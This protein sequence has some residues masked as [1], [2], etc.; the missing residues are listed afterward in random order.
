[1]RFRSQFFGPLS[2]VGL[3]IIAAFILGPNYSSWDRPFCT[4]TD[5]DSCWPSEL[6]W[7]DLNAS[8]GGRLIAP[9]PPASVCHDPNYDEAECAA[10]RE[11]WVWP[12]IHESWPGGIQSPYWQNSSCDPFSPVDIPC[13][14]GHSVSYAIN[15][16]NAE[17]VVQG[18]SFVRRHSLR[19]AIKNTGHD[20]MGKSTA[21]GGLALWTSSLRSIE[22]LDFASETY[23]GPAIRMGAGVR[24]LEAYT[25][26][27]NK[28]LRVVGGFCPT[29]GVAGGYTQGGG[30]GP[31]SSQYGLGADQVL[32]W[33]VITPSGEHVV[34][35]PLQHSDLYWALSGGGPGTYAVVISL[36]VRAYPDAYIGGATLAFSTAGVAKDD[37]WNFFKSWQDLLPSLTTAGGTA[38]YAVT[39]DA[40]FIAP[41]TLP[42]WTKQQVSGLISPLVDRLDE[43][44]VQYMLEVTSEPTFLKHYS[45][46]GGPLP[47]GPYT[48]HHLFGGRMI[49]RSIVE[50]NSTALVGAFRSILEDTDAFLGFVAL[51]VKQAPGREPVADNAVLPAWRDTLITVLAQSTWNFSALRADGQRHADEITDVVVPR[52]RELTLGSGTYMNEGDF[53]LKTWKED[54][55]G[56]NYPRLQAIKS[57]YDPEGLLFGPTGVSSDAWSVDEQGRLCKGWADGLRSTGLVRVAMLRAWA[58]L[59]ARARQAQQLAR[60]YF[61]ISTMTVTPGSSARASGS[62]PFSTSEPRVPL[63]PAETQPQRNAKLAGRPGLLSQPNNKIKTVYDI[64][65][66]AAETYGDKPALGSG[67]RAVGLQRTDK[68]LVYAATRQVF[69][70]DSSENPEID[71]HHKARNAYEALGL[72]GLEHSLESTGAKAIFVD[73]HLCQKV[74]SAMTNRALP[75]VEAIVYND[76]PSGTCDSG[77]AWIRGLFELKKTRPGLQILSFSQLCQ[78]GR[79]KM[80]EPVQPDREDLCAIYYTSGSTGIPKGVPVKHKAAVAAV[81]GLDSVIGDYLSPSDSFLAYL[82]LAHVLEFAFENSCLFWGVKMGYGGARTLFD[83]VT[84]SGTLGAGDLHAFQ[85][86][87]MI[88]VPAIWERI[89][90]AIFSSVENSSF[91]DRL[92]FWSWLKAKQIWAAAGFAGTGG[93]NGILSSAASEVVG[94]RLRFAMSGGGPVAESTQNFLTMVMAPLVNGYGLTETMAMGGLMDPGQWQPGSMS[95]PASIEMKLVDYPDAGYL[96]SNTPSQGEIWIRG[97]SVMEGYYDNDDES[98]SAV[99]PDGWLRTG[100]IGQ[101]EP[102]CSGDDFHFRIIDRKKNLVKTL[103]GEYIALEKLESIYRSANLVAN[104]CIHAS[105]YRAKPTAIVIPSPPALKELVKRHGLDTHCKVSALTR[106]PLVVHDALMQLQRIAQEAGL[107]SIEVVEAI[108]L[109]DDAEWTPQNVSA[110]IQN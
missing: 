19:L 104:I 14:L 43:L 105:P 108:V 63:V 24:G 81:T 51:D 78:V 9:V 59:T 5:G 98:K 12:E 10:I 42:G 61:E 23:T 106:H 70:L 65:N 8:V 86:T 102:T 82:P 50:E 48:I 60:G 79:S 38:G 95:I 11:D 92:A 97:D 67:L 17:D 88:G 13:T 34:A 26:A 72:A 18:L 71:A 110:I 84:P 47:R 29:V 22:V 57:K 74:T 3:A 25:A 80:S 101:W 64:V 37:F 1:M 7:Q 44:G 35:T 49:P 6:Q 69:P 87:F 30:H 15:V 83:H 52:L 68:I 16:T 93:F 77:A 27:A 31:L 45:K 55:Y 73:H 39:K 32:E 41:I 109:V 90:K 54:F 33:E 4:C 2:I 46:H 40:F 76:Q 99:A 20:Y 96:T 107:A 21:K 100:D 62:A 89:K 91:I 36:T 28:G 94:P 85:P 53:Q 56:A 75:R 66:W 58:T 103:N